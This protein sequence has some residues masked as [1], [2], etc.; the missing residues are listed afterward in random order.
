MLATS[1]LI[2]P[3]IEKAKKFVKDHP[4]LT[5]CIVTAVV[6]SRLSYDVACK[7]ILNDVYDQ[8]YQW[9]HQAGQMEVHL[10]EAYEF[11]DDKGLFEEFNNALNRTYG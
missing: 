7:D 11:I 4:T 6:T 2:R 10:L 9:G 1:R 5:A 3:E 8:T